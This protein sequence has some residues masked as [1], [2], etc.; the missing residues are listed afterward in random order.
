[1][2]VLHVDFL[3]EQLL[4]D[5]L[6]YGKECLINSRPPQ[7]LCVRGALN[8]MSGPLPISGS[9]R[10]SDSDSSESSAQPDP[11]F[12]GKP[13]ADYLPNVRF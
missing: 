5:I 2:I 7:W 3:A 13:G 9:C 6:I 8:V 11:W 4:L 10:T 12:P 1:M